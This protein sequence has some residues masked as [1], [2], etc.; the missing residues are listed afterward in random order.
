MEELHKKAVD[1]QVAY[2]KLR[3]DNEV[4]IFETVIANRKRER[5]FFQRSLDRQLDRTI[6]TMDT[7]GKSQFDVERDL[8]LIAIAEKYDN[9]LMNLEKEQATRDTAA[10]VAEEETMFKEREKLQEEQDKERAAFEVEI[11]KKKHEL[12][13]QLLKI[14]FAMQLRQIAVEEEYRRE[15]QKQQESATGA[16]YEAG[17]RALSEDDVRRMV[18]KTS[19]EELKPEDFVKAGREMFAAIEAVDKTLEKGFDGTEKEYRATREGLV[20]AAMGK[21]ASGKEI[22]DTA[23]EEEKEKARDERIAAEKEAAKIR[24][25][26]EKESIEAAKRAQIALAEEQ[27]RKAEE[28]RKREITATEQQQR[29]QNIR[30]VEASRAM[31]P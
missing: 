12:E 14:R 5:E 7:Y 27:D 21:D 4:K 6:A 10:V 20:R 24:A 17:G 15:L 30:C 25:V 2:N 31:L 18:G 1:R 16:G 22:Y 9:I 11:T 19:G 23:T 28:A 3:M 26:A 13:M 8:A 29:V